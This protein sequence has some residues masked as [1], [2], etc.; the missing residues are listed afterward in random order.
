MKCSRCGLELPPGT[1]TCPRCGTVN[2]FVPAQ[3]PRKTKPLVYAIAGLGVIALLALLVVVFAGRQNRS[4]VPVPPGAAG[5][6]GLTTVPPGDGAGGGLTSVPPGASGPGSTGPG[7][8]RRPKPSQAVVDYLSFVKKVEEHRQKLLK[9]TTTALTLTATGGGTQGMLDMIDMAMDPEG[10]KAIDP[11]AATKKELN[12]QY[13]NWLSTLKYFDSRSAP[14]ECR[15][16]SGAYREVLFR[17][18][19]AIGDITVSFRSVDITNPDD[20]SKLLK[21]LQGMKNDASIQSDI[22][23]SADDADAKLTK[24]VSNYDMEKPFDVPREQKTSGNIMGF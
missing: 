19:K 12:R 14:P 8:R 18:A 9:D 10:E 16:F 6:G 1:R 22:D 11:L 20:M 17:E 13:K 7:A 23:K 2:E 15:E 21:T 3:A 4:V 5:G 24:L